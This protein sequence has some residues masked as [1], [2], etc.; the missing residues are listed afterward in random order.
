M[1]YEGLVINISSFLRDRDGVHSDTLGPYDPSLS[2]AEQRCSPASIRCYEGALEMARLFEIFRKTWGLERT[3]VCF[4][5]WA[6]MAMVTLLESLVKTHS[7]VAFTGLCR[8]LRVACRRWMMARGLMR[9]VQLRARDMSLFQCMPIEAQ[10][11]FKDFEARDWHE[12]KAED[13]GS[14]CRDFFGPEFRKQ[15]ANETRP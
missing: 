11:M 5:H 6:T 15:K 3:P 4:N 13:C 7:H 10:D 9:M 1:L 8:F 2:P 12:E 14:I